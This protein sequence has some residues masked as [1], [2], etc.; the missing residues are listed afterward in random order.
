MFHASHNIYFLYFFEPVTLRNDLATYLV[1][2]QGLLLLFVE[3]LLAGFTLWAWRR[4][5]RA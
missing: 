4:S 3:L 5:L 1:G 2:E